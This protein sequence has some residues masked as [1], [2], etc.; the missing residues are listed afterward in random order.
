MRVVA[1]T[2]IRLVLGPACHPCKGT[3]RETVI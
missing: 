3:E 2:Q 1:D